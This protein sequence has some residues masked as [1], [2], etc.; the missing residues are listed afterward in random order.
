MSSFQVD[1]HNFEEVKKASFL[2]VEK[3]DAIKA[4]KKYLGTD[5]NFDDLLIKTYSENDLAINPNWDTFTYKNVGLESAQVA[6]ISASLN[7][8]KEF[9]YKIIFLNING[10]LYSAI[11]AIY[12]E[13]MHEGSL[14]DGTI[15]YFDLNG[16][17]SFGYTVKDGEVIHRLKKNVKISMAGLSLSSLFMQEGREIFDLGSEDWDLGDLDPILITANRWRPFEWHWSSDTAERD[18]SDDSGGRSEGEGGGEENEEPV[19]DPGSGKILDKNGEDCVCPDGMVENE[20]GVCREI[21]NDGLIDFGCGCGQ[22]EPINDKCRGDCV[23]N[24]T[25]NA[26]V[27][28]PSKGTISQEGIDLLKGIER[29]SLIPYDDKTKKRLTEW[30]KHATIGYGHLISES[31]FDKYKDGITELEAEALFKKDIDIEVGSLRQMRYNLT[32]NQFD[33]ILIFSYNI[34]GK[35]KGGFDKS[36]ARKLLE[37][38]EDEGSNYN[39]LEKAWKVFNKQEG[40]TL[41]GLQNR[42]NAEWNIFVKGVYE[43]W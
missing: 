22:P 30:N 17:Y 8:H 24:K 2:S 6:H 41:P 11:E 5:K 25:T 19:C 28:E 37:D 33:A 3:Q 16:K 38:C 20:A 31:E 42:R 14:N 7:V 26:P 1:D 9:T 23:E 15:L 43:R 12:V 32:Q 13:A 18:S 34:G 4:F 35:S 39:S 40:V 21:C 29:L 10:K 27:V 36:S